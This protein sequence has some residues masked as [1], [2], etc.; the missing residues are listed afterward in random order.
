[1]L[2]KVITG[3]IAA[4]LL[5]GGPALAQSS[6]TNSNAAQNNMHN[7]TTAGQNLPQRIRQKLQQQGFNEVKV[8]PGSFLVSAKDKDGDPV[9]MVIG[10]HS[11]TVFTML[12]SDSS[13]ANS[14]TGKSGTTSGQR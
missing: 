4:T 13:E 3:C 5:I 10:P 14:K 9:N 1:M 7:Q 6:S 8:V 2:V 12:S 11:M